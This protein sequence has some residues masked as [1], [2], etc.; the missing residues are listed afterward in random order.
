MESNENCLEDETTTDLHTFIQSIQQ[1][2]REE[3]SLPVH[4]NNENS[5]DSQ[6]TQLYPQ[7]VIE[8][9]KSILF[10]QESIDSY[11]NFNHNDRNTP[12]DQSEILST[13]GKENETNEK[14]EGSN[15]LESVPKKTKA[16]KKRRED[17]SIPDSKYWNDSSSVNLGRRSKREEIEVLKENEKKNEVVINQAIENIDLN[18][19]EETNSKDVSIAEEKE[20]G[21]ATDETA[22]NTIL[23]EDENMN[24]EAKE[25]NE[26]EE[27]GLKPM[28]CTI[29]NNNQGESINNPPNEIEKEPMNDQEA[30]QEETD[31]HFLPSQFSESQPSQEPEID[32]TVESVNIEEERK[33]IERANLASELDGPKWVVRDG[34]SR[35]R[36]CTQRL[37]LI[38][39]QFGPDSRDEKVS[40]YRINDEYQD[41]EFFEAEEAEIESSEGEESDDMESSQDENELEPETSENE[42]ES[43]EEDDLIPNY[44]RNP[45]Q[46][47]VFRQRSRAPRQPGQPRK[48]KDRRNDNRDP[49]N[50]P[51]KR[52]RTIPRPPNQNPPFRFPRPNVFSNN[53]VNANMPGNSENSQDDYD[54][55][56]DSQSLESEEDSNDSHTSADSSASVPHSTV[57]SSKRE[58]STC[59]RRIELIKPKHGTSIRPT[60]YIPIEMEGE[61]VDFEFNQFLLLEDYLRGKK[62]SEWDCRLVMRA[63]DTQI[64]QMSKAEENLDQISQFLKRSNVV[65]NLIS[66]EPNESNQKGIMASYLYGKNEPKLHF[67][68]TQCFLCV[69]FLEWGELLKS[70]LIDLVRVEEEKN[71]Q[72]GLEIITETSVLASKMSLEQLGIRFITELVELFM[73]T[74]KT[75]KL[76][77]SGETHLWN[78][79][80]WKKIVSILIRNQ[81]NVWG[82]LNGILSEKREGV[83]SIDKEKNQIFEEFDVIENQWRILFNTIQTFMFSEE[84]KLLDAPDFIDSCNWL[85]V[86][87]LLKRSPVLIDYSSFDQME[88]GI[89]E[90]FIIPLDHQEDPT[91]FYCMEILRRFGTVSSLW[92]PEPLLCKKIFYRFFDGQFC[93]VGKFNPDFAVCLPF[94]YQERPLDLFL[95]AVE[96]QLEKG[97]SLVSF[98]SEVIG[99]HPLYHSDEPDVTIISSGKNL[100]NVI[101]LSITCARHVETSPIEIHE[102]VTKYAN[103][104]DL[105]STMI[106]VEGLLHLILSY[107]D[108]QIDNSIHWILGEIE[109][110]LG[111]HVTYQRQELVREKRTAKVTKRNEIMEGL[112]ILDSCTKHIL[113][114]IQGAKEFIRKEH[115]I[116]FINNFSFVMNIF[117]INLDFDLTCTN[118]AIGILDEIIDSIKQSELIDEKIRDKFEEDFLPNVLEFI[119]NKANNTS[120]D[121]LNVTRRLKKCMIIIFQDGGKKINGVQTWLE[122]FNSSKQKVDDLEWMLDVKSFLSY[123]STYFPVLSFWFVQILCNYQSIRKVTEKLIRFQ[124]PNKNLPLFEGFTNSFIRLDKD[125]ECFLQNAKR[126]MKVEE[127]ITFFKGIDTNRLVQTGTLNNVVVNNANTVSNNAVSG[128]KA[129]RIEQNNNKEPKETEKPNKTIIL[130]VVEKALQLFYDVIIK[131]NCPLFQ[132]LYNQSDYQLKGEISMEEN[133]LN[134][135]ASTWASQEDIMYDLLMAML[136]KA[137]VSPFEICSKFSKSFVS[138]VGLSV[139]MK[140]KIIGSFIY[141]IR[142]YPPTQTQFNV[143]YLIISLETELINHQDIILPILKECYYLSRRSLDPKN[144]LTQDLSNKLNST[145]WRFID[146]LFRNFVPSSNNKELENALKVVGK[147]LVYMAIWELATRDPKQFSNQ[148]KEEKNRKFLDEIDKTRKQLFSE[149]KKAFDK[150]PSPSYKFRLHSLPLPEPSVFI[151]YKGQ[152]VSF[153]RGISKPNSFGSS[154]IPK[155]DFDSLVEKLSAK[156][157]VEIMLPSKK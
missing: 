84:G 29:D 9:N 17:L 89:K 137:V 113:R 16:K 87:E 37:G 6:S 142:Q 41:E 143:F 125:M 21:N 147:D 44:E 108:K 36:K 124:L 100:W 140:A 107:S 144:T 76:V 77:G 64:L 26:R 45:L 129:K 151:P 154:F 103:K 55:L 23:H 138:I 43:D 33:R 134:C 13:L 4:E 118:L 128:M 74:N 20:A 14:R 72:T 94:K 30:M 81:I 145:I 116:Y 99:G 96:K 115:L 90:R 141:H 68:Y 123:E 52:R 106:V 59:L 66:I 56:Y 39:Y 34:D 3:S 63:L 38:E 120:I 133:Y 149:T 95:M 50:P 2:E 12:L 102:L 127:R 71:A 10:N 57:K 19:K 42:D 67:I 73:C 112:A 48:K 139:D 61:S 46:N 49:N 62:D 132:F 35:V 157:C 98:L 40:R 146:R 11:N 152:I 156:T 155:K 121:W 18:Q 136:K 93:G 130:W 131:H 47:N 5:V 25:G 69:R 65:L 79:F 150:V 91:S 109:P 75:T 105:K 78:S 31:E 117:D 60:Y 15:E 24:E 22:I 122:M 7:D 86:E 51:R 54:P 32:L 8:N 110:M 80:L 119:S 70:S 104:E 88:K 153:L 111:V 82:I 1:N 85:L 126:F 101:L 114:L 148:E 58:L 83:Q 28:E 53:A 97:Q 92:R 135:I 27:N